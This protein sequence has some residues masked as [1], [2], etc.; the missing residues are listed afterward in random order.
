MPSDSRT[1]HQSTNKNSQNNTKSL[2]QT[3]TFNF[4]NPGNFEQL[5][6]L[7]KVIG[8]GGFGVVYSGIRNSDKKLVS[9]M[10]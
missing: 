3:P 1:I 10:T 7:N 8:N 2:P 4:P 6:S 9:V 5:Y